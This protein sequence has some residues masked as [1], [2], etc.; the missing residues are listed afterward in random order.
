MTFGLSAADYRPVDVDLSATGISFSLTGPSGR[1]A[2]KSRLIGAFNM[3]NLSAAA[4]TA[5]ELGVDEQAVSAGLLA[6]DN[7]SGRF[8]AVNCGQDF[9]VLV[10][11]A[12][13]P[14]GLEKVLSAAKVL[15][16]DK[17]LIAVFG[18]GGD[19]DKGKRPKMGRI[20][21]RL[22]DLAIVTSD[23]PRSES[24]RTIID[25]ILRGIPK[26]EG[27]E[28]T[29][30]VERAEAIRAAMARAG[31]GDVVVIAGKGHEDYQILKD[32]TIPF[33]DRLVATEALKELLKHGAC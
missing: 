26:S 7:V 15:A 21:A 33:D 3:T 14:D 31:P 1:V 30:I 29:V 27:A 5:L 16:A 24:P 9:Q 12:H 18:C 11:Y 32:R 20:A 17:R 19:R 4:T 13:T 28:T 23:N 25:D 22:S 6:V 8:E 2:V 10:D